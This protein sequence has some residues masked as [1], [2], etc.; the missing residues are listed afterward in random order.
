M[1]TDDSIP[2]AV[3]LSSGTVLSGCTL[4]NVNILSPAKPLEEKVV[5][6]EGRPQAAPSDIAGF[7]S[8]KESD[9]VL[10]AKQKASIVSRVR[11]SLRKAEQDDDIAGSFYASIRP[12]ERCLP[13]ISIIT[14][15]KVPEPQKGSRVRLYYRTGDI[16]AYYIATASE[17]NHA[18]PT[19]VTGSIGV[20]CSISTWRA[21][22]KIGVAEQ[23]IKSGSKKDLMSPFRASTAEERRNMQEIIDSLARRFFDVI[24]ARSNNQLERQ[25]LEEAGGRAGLHG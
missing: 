1:H 6:G 4:F 23:S 17:S 14:R 10:P 9:G 20:I 21:F 5:E 15:Y 24:M 11:E 25:E 2:A 22:R 8:G 19:A 3:R 16:G 18:H 7:I 12:A 13:V